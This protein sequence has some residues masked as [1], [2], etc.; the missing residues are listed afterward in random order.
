MSSL[1]Y[2]GFKSTLS[3]KVESATKNKPK[4]CIALLNFVQ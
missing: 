3:F 1:F 4:T 2:I